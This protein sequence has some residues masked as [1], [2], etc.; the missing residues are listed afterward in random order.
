M[1]NIYFDLTEAFNA[2]QVTVALASGQAV[3][4]YRV[5]IMSKDGDW[6]VRETPDACE[7]VLA[8]LEKRGATID[9]SRWT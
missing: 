9:C 2:R 5:A 3:V 4:Y 6:I 8:E 1:G 7:Q